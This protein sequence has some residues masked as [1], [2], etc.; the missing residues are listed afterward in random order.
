MSNPVKKKIVFLIQVELDSPL[1][2]ASGKT[3]LTD[4]DVIRDYDGNPFVP[5]SSVAGAM[6][7]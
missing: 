7:R 6:R 3:G 4:A 1:C 5:A 2:I